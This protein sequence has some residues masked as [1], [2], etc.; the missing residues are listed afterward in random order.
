MR[1]LCGPVRACACLTD[2]VQAY[3]AAALFGNMPLFDYALR[4]CSR[5]FRS[6]GRAPAPDMRPE[7]EADIRRESPTNYTTIMFQG[8]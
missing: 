4:K 5:P 3:A 6:V 8:I 1:S 2:L 7:Q